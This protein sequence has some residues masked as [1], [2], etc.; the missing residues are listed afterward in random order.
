MTGPDAHP[1]AEQL[2]LFTYDSQSQLEER[3]ARVEQSW[4]E[5]SCRRS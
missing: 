1:S 5:L 3:Q 4:A 2:D